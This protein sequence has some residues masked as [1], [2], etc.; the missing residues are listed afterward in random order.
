[1]AGKDTG[2]KINFDKNDFFNEAQKEICDQFLNENENP[3]KLI[4]EAAI[5]RALIESD[6]DYT[7]YQQLMKQI[8]LKGIDFVLEAIDNHKRNPALNE[9]QIETIVSKIILSK[10]LHS[11]SQQSIPNNDQEKASKPKEERKKPSKKLMNL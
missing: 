3:N 5:H 7:R 11:S 2:F 4:K 10:G 9:A 1:M 8:Q 6:S